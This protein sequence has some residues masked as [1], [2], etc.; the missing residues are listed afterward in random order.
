MTPMNR[1]LLAV[2]S[3]V[4]VCALGVAIFGT[5]QARNHPKPA[6]SSD[7]GN[8]IDR[9]MAAVVALF[10]APA[11][12]TPCESAYN[13]FKA[14]L[15]VST[16][17]NVTPIVLWLAPHDD[18]IARCSALPP[19]TQ[20]CMVPQY[21]SQHRSECVAAKPPDAVLESMAKLKH[22]S[23]PEQSDMPSEPAPTAAP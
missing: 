18:F 4:L 21:M 10:H 17:Q 12:A 19:A 3:V 13:A 9:A 23:E 15:D 16:V 1:K 6:P 11:G 22:A 7:H 5:V 8:G 2:A 20:Q 14:S